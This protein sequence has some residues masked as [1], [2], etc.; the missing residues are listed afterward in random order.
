MLWG[1]VLFIH[2]GQNEKVILAFKQNY[3]ATRNP[4]HA[5]H[6][7]TIPLTLLMGRDLKFPYTRYN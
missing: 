6:T 3:N 5:K 7:V 4:L 2:K 1:K